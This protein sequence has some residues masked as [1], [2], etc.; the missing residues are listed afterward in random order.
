MVTVILSA[1]ANSADLPILGDAYQLDPAAANPNEN[2]VYGY[3]FN[4]NRDQ[5]LYVI[6]HQRHMVSVEGSADQ[7]EILFD[8]GN[9]SLSGFPAGQP[10][11]FHAYV[12]DDGSVS[13]VGAQNMAYQFGGTHG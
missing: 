10:A 2:C 7:Q 11:T 12:P 6:T 9:T 4:V 3:P 1:P 5:G 13:G 8:A